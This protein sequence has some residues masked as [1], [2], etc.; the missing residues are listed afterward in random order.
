[1]DPGEIHRH[2]Q[3]YTAADGKPM[4]KYFVVLAKRPDGD[5]VL[6]LL[7]SKPRPH[8]PSCNH[9]PPYPSYFLGVLGG[10]LV[11]ESSV[12]LRACD[13]MEGDLAALQAR[14]GIITSIMR[15][16]TVTF[17]AIL[18]CAAGSGDATATQ[19]KTMR[20]LLATLR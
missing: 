4:P 15:L 17:C 11:A 5:I 19:E 1:M 8:A 16:S 2:A 12:D 3:Y 14:K 20:D 10:R 13:D 7:T 9:G 6:R 18:E